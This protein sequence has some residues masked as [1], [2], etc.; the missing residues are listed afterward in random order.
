M[1]LT[2]VLPGRTGYHKAVCQGAARSV[3][4]AGSEHHVL[5]TLM[6]SVWG[7]DTR[8]SFS[9]VRPAFVVL[10]KDSHPLTHEVLGAIT[11]IGK[12]QVVR[13]G[14]KYY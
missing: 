12:K 5:S 13:Q 7:H 1:Q 2:C 3:L 4:Q 8:F 10:I 11:A 9:G 6:P 14:D